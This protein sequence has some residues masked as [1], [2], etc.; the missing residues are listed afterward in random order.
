M[1]DEKKPEIVNN[2]EVLEQ[3]KPAIEEIEEK[4]DAFVDEEVSFV[5]ESSIKIKEEITKVIVGQEQVIDLLL[6][7]L[8]VDGHILLEGVPGIAKTLLAKLFARTMSVGYSRVQ[9]TPD[10]MPT[11]VTGTMVFDNNSSTFNFRKG[12]VFSNL[13]LIDEINRAPAKTQA[14]LFE[15][16]QEKQ[17]SIDGQTYKMEEP[18]MIMAT[19]NPIEQEGTYKL[20][21]AQLDRFTYRLKL[22]YPELE[23]EKLILRRFKNKTDKTASEDVSS[24]IDS[25]DVLRIKKIVNEVEISDQL[26]D[27]IANI[28]VNTRNNADIFLGASSRASLAIMNSSKAIA[29]I[30]GRNFVTPDDIKYVAKHVMNHRII[31]NSDLEIE[32]VSTEEVID[33]ILSKIE[34][35]R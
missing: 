31:L 34:I 19:Q 32:G 16:M 1:E 9:F 8:Y 23:D 21:E 33:S 22:N 20:P 15:V 10:L 35:P 5:Y 28:I 4:P 26:L 12:P 24:V 14:A 27:F 6:S 17:I 18:Y 13:V 2:T 25:A 3:A 30:R 11:D 29:A 7:A